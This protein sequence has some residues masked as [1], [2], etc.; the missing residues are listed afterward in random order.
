MQPANM[1]SQQ[2]NLDSPSSN[3][4]V[5]DVCLASSPRPRPILP[6]PTQTLTKP[7]SLCRFI[8]SNNFTNS[9][10]GRHHDAYSEDVWGSKKCYST[11][12]VLLMPPRFGDP[13]RPTSMMATS[14]MKDT[15]FEH[16]KMPPHQ[17]SL[18]HL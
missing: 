14:T 16:R 15:R 10:D 4:E 18:I 11:D 1:N 2:Q 8:V 5:N 13:R 6:M 17:M 9:S 12:R 3:H 7:K